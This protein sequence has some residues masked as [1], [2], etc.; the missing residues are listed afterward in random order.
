[1][2]FCSS[3]TYFLESHRRHWH[4]RTELRNGEFESFLFKHKKKQ[5]NSKPNP[6]KQRQ[7]LRAVKCISFGNHSNTHFTNRN[8][9]RREPA[10]IWGTST[11]KKQTGF[12]EQPI[13]GKQREQGKRNPM[14]FWG[15]DRNGPKQR[16]LSERR[17]RREIE[18]RLPLGHW[19]RPLKSWFQLKW[20]SWNTRSIEQIQVPNGDL[21]HCQLYSTLRLKVSHHG[22]GTK[23]FI[24]LWISFSFLKK[25]IWKVQNYENIRSVVSKAAIAWLT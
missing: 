19:R 8:R 10:S 1:M 17:E 6:A 24:E 5:V 14:T 12:V 2:I 20:C 3:A 16:N 23:Y 7:S 18:W 21:L 11:T 13:T 25:K 15:F 4:S 9:A 22:F